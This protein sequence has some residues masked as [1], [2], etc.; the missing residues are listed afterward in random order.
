MELDF[1][2]IDLAYETNIVGR[3]AIQL[4]GRTINNEK[5]LNEAL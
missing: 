1:F 2:P 5:I 3:A 4:F